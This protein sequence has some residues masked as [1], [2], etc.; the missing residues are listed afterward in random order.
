M[1]MGVHFPKGRKEGLFRFRK[2]GWVVT[3]RFTEKAQHFTE[4]V[5]R[6]SEKDN[7]HSPQAE[8]Q[9]VVQPRNNQ[10]HIRLNAYTKT[11]IPIYTK[12]TSTF[13]QNLLPT[14]RRITAVKESTNPT[15]LKKPNLFHSNG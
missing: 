10:N 3:Q 13:D 9:S 8:Q 15:A 12:Y 5:F 4:R 11:A 6:E 2:M 14:R 1:K 7:N